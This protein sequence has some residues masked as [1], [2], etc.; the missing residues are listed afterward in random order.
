MVHCPSTC[1]WLHEGERA[2]QSRANFE[3]NNNRVQ[4]ELLSVQNQIY[5]TIKGYYLTI[6]C[7]VSPAMAI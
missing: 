1:K 4:L 3:V 5:N 2:V 7:W 6:L